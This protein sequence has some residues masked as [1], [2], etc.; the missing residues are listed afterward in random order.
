M[1]SCLLRYNYESANGITA[2]ETGDARGDGTKAH[3]SY[4]FT[5]P[6]GE[7]VSVTYTA[8]ENGFVPQGSHIP[9]PP[10][11]PEAI[12]KALQENAAAEA[13]GIFDDGQYKGEGLNEGEYHGEGENDGAYKGESEVNASGA[14]TADNGGYKY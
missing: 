11:I 6:N 14:K 3:G 12:L 5:L 7:H 8:D 1:L 10:P 13:R 9:T 2:E 4:S